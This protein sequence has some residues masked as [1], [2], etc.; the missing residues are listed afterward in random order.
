MRDA[1]AIACRREA[2]DMVCPNVD[3]HR[4][5]ALVDGRTISVLDPCQDHK[6]VGEGDVGPNTGGM[7]AYSPAPV[8]SAEIEAKSIKVSV[9]D[10][11]VTLDGHVHAWAERTA[12]ERAAWS[13]PGVSV[14][15]DRIAVY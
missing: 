10:G 14:V 8:L 1:R 12:A 11:S 4:V 9:A 5:L 13:A 7:G 15:H 6:Q 2:A 3:R